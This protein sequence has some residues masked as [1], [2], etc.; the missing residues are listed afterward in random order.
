MRQRHKL[1]GHC[2][3]SSICNFDR[4][5][6]EIALMMPIEEEPEDSMTPIPDDVADAVDAVSPGKNML[7][8]MI[9][10]QIIHN[11]VIEE[12]R[13]SIVNDTEIKMS[14]AN[15]RLFKRSAH[16][17]FEK[18]FADGA[19]LA[20]NISKGLKN[21]YKALEETNYAELCDPMQWLTVYDDVMAV[22]E[23]YILQ[24][25]MRMIVDIK[26]AEGEEK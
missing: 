16:L 19:A 6:S 11:K 7:K 18:Y 10:L 15:L 9:S 3:Q 8:G 14:A 23:D 20:I 21:K 4:N 22:M 1:Y 2:P 13:K 26:S 12:K 25:Y 5:L 24:S 17:L